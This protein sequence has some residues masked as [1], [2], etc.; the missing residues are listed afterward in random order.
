MPPVETSSLARPVPTVHGIRRPYPRSWRGAGVQ[1]AVVKLGIGAGNVESVST[2]AKPRHTAQADAVREALERVDGFRSAQEVYDAL[3]GDA[4]SVGLTTVYRQ[5]Q[6]LAARGVA[7]VIVS[8]DGTTS[9]RYCRAPGTHHHHLVC[10][11]CGRAEEVEGPAIE[12]WT[13]AVAE[14]FGYTDVDH[15]VEIFGIC[16][17]C[18]R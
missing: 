13:S 9:Y 15:T 12:R 14:Q 17:S 18:A 2:P 6:R 10:R 8:P 7:D 11:G 5:L 4:Q 16:S 3:R 1:P